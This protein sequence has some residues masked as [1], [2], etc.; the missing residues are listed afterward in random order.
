MDHRTSNA[1]SFVTFLFFSV[2]ISYIT[3]C[4]AN[5]TPF[6]SGSASGGPWY[7]VHLVRAGP[8]WTGDRVPRVG[9]LLS[10]P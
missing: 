8:P 2:L 10:I 7:A 6:I 4:Q 5:H 3:T 9:F 1:P